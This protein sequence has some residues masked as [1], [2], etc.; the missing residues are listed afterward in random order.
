MYGWFDSSN[1]PSPSRVTRSNAVGNANE[2]PA[3]VAYKTVDI[4][5]KSS[6]DKEQDISELSFTDLRDKILA[7]DLLDKDL[8]VKANQAEAD[9]WRK[10][11][12][13]RV[14]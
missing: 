1:A 6:E 3:T 13:Y 5:A 14:G 9:F 8:V 4:K 10:S 7:L 11:E 2:T 12:G